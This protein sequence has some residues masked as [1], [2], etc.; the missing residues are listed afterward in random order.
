[1]FPL[2]KTLLY[3]IKHHILPCFDPTTGEEWAEEEEVVHG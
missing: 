3:C 2:A 1:M